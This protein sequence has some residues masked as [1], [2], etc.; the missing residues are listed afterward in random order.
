[1]KRA[2]YAFDPMDTLFFRD[3]RPFDQNDPGMSEAVSLLPPT[4]DTVS[5]ALCTALGRRFGAIPGT[6]WRPRIDALRESGDAA[7]AAALERLATRTD[8]GGLGPFLVEEGPTTNFYFPIPRH[9]LV[10]DEWPRSGREG[11]PWTLL[12]PDQ[13][14]LAPTMID[15][16][17][18]QDY[19]PRGDLWIRHD[20]LKQILAGTLPVVAP[21]MLVA[22]DEIFPK[23]R[24]VGIAREH[25]TRTVAEGMLYA[26]AHLRPAS[27]HRFCF[28][29][30]VPEG[31]DQD[32]GDLRWIPFGGEGRTA[33][34]A[35]APSIAPLN[36]QFGRSGTEALFV[37]T[38][39]TAT[40]LNQHTN[41]RQ[42][43][44]GD[45]NLELVA[46]ATDRPLWF[47]GW[48]TERKL[49]RPVRPLLPAGTSWFVRWKV[50]SGATDET[51]RTRLGELQRGSLADAPQAS[52]GYG[53]FA[54]GR[55]PAT[56]GKP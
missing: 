29:M 49:P 31:A 34:I 33:F 17:K 9:V 36:P 7:A 39:L 38:L 15:A 50:G 30:D 42:I 37:V 23:E 26:A 5:G 14:E 48:D 53:R 27:R 43:T 47:G 24:R 21:G 35:K 13:G 16:G 2:C 20:V 18:E 25:A 56:G 52:L 22:L 54:I 40:P 45:L 55:W 8:L 6:N 19:A 51:I 1:M 28:E 32:L 46:C 4:P 41:P 3:A 12:S 11:P 44:L 10:H